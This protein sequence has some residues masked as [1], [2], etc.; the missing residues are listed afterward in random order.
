MEG[1]SREFYFDYGRAQMSYAGARIL[2]VSDDH[3]APLHS[4]EGD[5]PHGSSATAR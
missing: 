3:R 5:Q 1:S 2:A 4:I